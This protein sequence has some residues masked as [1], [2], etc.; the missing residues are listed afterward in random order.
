MHVQG[1][2]LLSAGE[3]GYTFSPDS[4][5]TS[6]ERI[7][8]TGYIITNDGREAL[9]AFE[10]EAVRYVADMED[11]TGLIAYDGAIEITLSSEGIRLM[12][13]HPDYPDSWPKRICPKR[14]VSNGF[15]RFAIVS[16]LLAN[17]I[18]ADPW[19][20]KHVT[21]ATMLTDGNALIETD[22]FSVPMAIWVGN[23]K[24]RMDKRLLVPA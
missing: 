8:M 5:T 20:S 13:P 23:P 22:G 16:D 2:P 9:E 18:M 10:N 6:P 14:A 1:V 7:N 3:V 15:E 24:I 12:E 4:T 11:G 17:D 21:A 19:S